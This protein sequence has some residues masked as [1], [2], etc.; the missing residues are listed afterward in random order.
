M[1]WSY[2]G[3]PTSCPKDEV[4]F[5]IGD[6]DPDFAFIQDEEILFL[7]TKSKDSV[8]SASI[9]AVKRVIAQVARQVDY[10][11]GPEQVYA[12]QRLANFRT[13]LKQLQEELSGVDHIQLSQPATGTPIFDI[14]MNDCRRVSWPDTRGEWTH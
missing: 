10:K 5:V 1:T 14:G 13:L 4:R 8:S 3:D 6:T 11:I 7:L 2:S 12:S 9:A